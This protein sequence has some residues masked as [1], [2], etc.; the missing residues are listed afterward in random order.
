[1]SKSLALIALAFISSFMPL[2]AQSQRYGV[3]IITHGFT[4]GGNISEEWVNFA[5]AVQKRAKA[6]V[7]YINDGSTGL[8][9]S[10]NA[11]QVAQKNQEIIIL[12]DWAWAS[13]NLKEGYLEACAEHLAALINFLPQELSE[14]KA[15]FWQR[16]FHLIGHSRGGILMLQLAQRLAS[17]AP[18][19]NFK[20]EQL[21]LL[22]AHPAA[23]MGDCRLPIVLGDCPPPKGYKS[24]D[25]QLKIPNIVE[26]VD[27]YFRQDGVY[28]DFINE[29][30]LGAYD[31]LA[32]KGLDSANYEL[33]NQLLSEGSPRMGGAHAS[34]ATR[35]YYGTID[36]ENTAQ[37]DINPAWY[38]PNAEYPYMADR[39]KTGYYHS[40]LGG[41]KLPPR[42]AEAAKMPVK[43][44]ENWIFNGNFDINRKLW[45][46][47]IPGWDGNGAGGGARI[48]EIENANYALRLEL[49]RI[50][51]RSTDKAIN[52]RQHSWL[53]FPTHIEGKS[54]G[55]SFKFRT[56][57]EG[58]FPS[59]LQLGFIPA[60][61]PNIKQPILVG[62]TIK[63]DERSQR[64]F[65]EVFYEL[66]LDFRGRSGTLRFV[67]DGKRSNQVV[68]IDEV[69]LKVK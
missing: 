58:K 1:M 12:Y 31:G 44:P 8:L 69:V 40:R 37:H 32:V 41:G 57:D 60:E 64:N 25:L 47:L 68:E 27:N 50:S 16:P 30:I 7:I 6:G 46:G 17:V 55:I 65:Q 24:Q 14:S 52:W 23:P 5:K 9:K 63:L 38:A 28:E 15:E 59:T 19:P 29:K 13:N 54:Y 11:A 2:A 35:W 48:I 53:Y 62:E 66:P 36:W 42:L 20:I 51:L 3:T 45:K 21:T 61:A 34:I 39:Q 10:I 26:R 33:S 18:N 67:L 22:D 49:P 43:L 4:P 56:L